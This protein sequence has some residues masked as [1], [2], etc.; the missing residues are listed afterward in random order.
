MLVGF[1]RDARTVGGNRIDGNR[2]GGQ[3]R[4]PKTHPGVGDLFAALRSASSTHLR[5][6]YGHWAE[7]ASWAQ[8]PDTATA[9]A[10]VTVSGIHSA[11]LVLQGVE[12]LRSV[13][14]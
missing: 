8:T 9:T 11:A 13:A 12:S 5:L 6:L 7:V 14:E 2:I 4:I 10:V 1:H 3:Q